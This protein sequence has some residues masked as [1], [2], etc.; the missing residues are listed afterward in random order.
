MLGE[1]SKRCP[2]PTLAKRC[3]N[4]C[5]LL[6]AT[7]SWHHPWLA[8]HSS[9]RHPAMDGPIACSMQP[10]AGHSAAAARCTALCQLGWSSCKCKAKRALAALL[11]RMR[12]SRIEQDR[13]GSLTE[14]SP[15]VAGAGRQRRGSPAWRLGR[16]AQGAP[17]PALGAQAW[18][19]MPACTLP[20]VSAAGRAMESA[21]GCCCTAGAAE[22]C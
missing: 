9:W 11:V 3:V 12:S 21:P 17:L 4:C 22:P 10:P 19:C 16:S 7:A 20:G 2:P 6:H 8:A 15:R 5:K 14:R 1:P 18:R 13:P